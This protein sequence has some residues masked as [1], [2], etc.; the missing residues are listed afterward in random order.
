MGK[1]YVGTSHHTNSVGLEVTCAD[2]HLPT[3]FVPKMIRKVRAAV[4]ER[5]G[6]WMA[7]EVRCLAPTGTIRRTHEAL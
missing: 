7:C 1:E 4:H 6:L 5:T 3:E 2:C